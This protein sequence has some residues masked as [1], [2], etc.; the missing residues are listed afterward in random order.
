M[1]SRY[2][3]PPPVSEL[4]NEELSLIEEQMLPSD[5][6]S[7][8]GEVTDPDPPLLDPF[9]VLSFDS[10]ESRLKV[11]VL[12][13]FQE[14]VTLFIGTNALFKGKSS[15]QDFYKITSCRDL[16]LWFL[17]RRAR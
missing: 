5:V 9:F 3:E 12:A 17:F 15:S 4:R 13:M 10:A 1:L 16:V 14:C 11:L 8:V 7:C 2:E 6:S